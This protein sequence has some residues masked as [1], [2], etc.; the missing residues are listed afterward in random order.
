[1]TSTERTITSGDFQ[2]N[3][4]KQCARTKKQHE[5]ES[6]IENIGSSEVD[7][8]VLQK[9]DSEQKDTKKL[10]KKELHF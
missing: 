6:L 5:I 4:G 2:M 1:M 10:T 7:R 9:K 3:L 8:E